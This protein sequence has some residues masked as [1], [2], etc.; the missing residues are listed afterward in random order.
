MGVTASF[1]HGERV[2]MPDIAQYISGDVS[3]VI[4]GVK[5]LVCSPDGPKLSRERDA[6]DLMSAAWEQ[7]ASLVA[8][9]VERLS[10]DFFQLS[11]RLA[12]D[13]LQKFVNHRLRVA[14]VGDVSAWT[15]K[16]KALHDFVS[17][18]NGGQTVWFVSDL[19][20]LERLLTSAQR[21]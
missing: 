4:G 18:S 20:E 9:P 6:N 14:I 5:V 16:S 13:V 2:T 1:R 10:A 17:E 11:T 3:R 15:A 21:T 19:G 12:G 8:I 7:S